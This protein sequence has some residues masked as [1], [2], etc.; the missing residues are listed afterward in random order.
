MLYIEAYNLAIEEMDKYYF[1][2]NPDKS[3]DYFLFEKNMNKSGLKESTG[4]LLCALDKLKFYQSI[5]NKEDYKCDAC[6]ENLKMLWNAIKIVSFLISLPDL[7]FKDLLY[8]N[9]IL[10]IGQLYR[11]HD[12]F[13][14][15]LPSINQHLQTIVLSVHPDSVKEIQSGDKY[16]FFRARK[17][18]P[19]AVPQISPSFVKRPLTFT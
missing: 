19:S 10:S 18:D 5:K 6:P 4:D 8:H 1:G 2:E 16:K 7:N 3:F 15:V 11:L 9:I 13:K 17:S 12:Q 14:D